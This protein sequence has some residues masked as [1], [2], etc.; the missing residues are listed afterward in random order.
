MRKEGRGRG[1]KIQGRKR[2][3]PFSPLKS[4]SRS[5]FSFVPQKSAGP[6]R[7]FHGRACGYLAMMVLLEEF[8]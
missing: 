7:N 4:L 8:M 3:S 5:L 6:S 2:R 1:N